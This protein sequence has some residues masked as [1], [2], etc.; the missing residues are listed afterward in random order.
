V[1]VCSADLRW[2]DD[3]CAASSSSSW[4][5]SPR[6]ACAGQT[7]GPFVG[8]RV[9]WHLLPDGRNNSVGAH[10]EVLDALDR[11]RIPYVVY[12]PGS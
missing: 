8:V 12:P 9:E 3:S 4:R 11:N 5:S 2:V 7:L 6:A 10:P 1:V